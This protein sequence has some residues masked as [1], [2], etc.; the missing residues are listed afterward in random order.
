[1]N[2]KSLLLGSAAALVAVSGARAADAIVAAEPEPVEYVRVCDA[3][4]TGYFY[5]PGT[6]TCLRIGGYMRVEGFGGT[7]Y[8]QITGMAGKKTYNLHTR[9]SLQVSTA[10]ETELGTLRTFLEVRHNWNTSQ[11]PIG[12]APA[13]TAPG[14]PGYSNGSTIDLNHAW[15]QLGGLRFG[16][17]DSFF[18]TWTGYAG[19][20]I[21][22]WT[23]VKYGLFGT[24]LI[25]YTVTGGAWRAG[26]SLEQ[27]DSNRTVVAATATTPAVTAGWGIDDYMPHV[28]A[29]L[30][31]TAG[32]VDLSGTIGWD[33]RNAAGQGG[34]AGKIR[35]NVKFNDAASAFLMLMY[36]QNTSAY[37]AWAI[38]GNTNTFAVIG[39]G[40]YAFTDKA[41]FNFQ[42]GWANA[43]TPV[44][45]TWNLTAN[46]AYALVPGLTITPEVSWV[47]TAG[48]GSVGAGIRAQRSF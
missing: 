42:A 25:S 34:W 43:P 35:A 30:G 3:F 36:G 8:T 45:D 31:F 38:A 40:S 27:G 7:P 6:E 20:V 14:A 19:S 26:L 10:S 44:K 41:T 29:G 28:V 33:S 12:V 47:S 32:M 1:M 22:D 21:N 17:T 39:G 11:L 23:P 16:K 37:T 24:H 4:G 46:V 5:I 2:I 48:V 13:F 18:T 9:S 15:I